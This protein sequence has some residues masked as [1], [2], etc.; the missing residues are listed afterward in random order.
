MVNRDAPLF[1]SL[2]VRVKYTGSMNLNKLHIK[3][4]ETEIIGRYFLRKGQLVPDDNCERVA[5][6]I[7]G[8]LEF[9]AK[10]KTGW[11]SLY[12]DPNDG[13]YWEKAYLQNE[14]HGGG[15]ASLR[16]VTKRKLKEEQPTR[17][18]GKSRGDEIESR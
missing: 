9:M 14:T 11:T 5:Q 12:K 3:P 17:R 8:Y 13:R 10:D 6:L 4:H 1:A 7:N 15:P 18:I 16:V 2:S